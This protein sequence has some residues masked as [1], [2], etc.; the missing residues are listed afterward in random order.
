MPEQ[1][2]MEAR[3]QRSGLV[4]AIPAPAAAT[5]SELVG[6]YDLHTGAELRKLTETHSRM[7]ARLPPSMIYYIMILYNITL[8]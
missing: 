5:I 4:G 2:G 8:Y 6:S 3:Q 7:T 1:G